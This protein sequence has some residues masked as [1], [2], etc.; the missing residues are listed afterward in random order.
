MKRASILAVYILAVASLGFAQSFIPG[1]LPKDP[2]SMGMGGS[3]RVFATGYDAFFGNPAGFSGP[4]SL[5]LADIAAWA[6]FEPYPKNIADIVAIAEGEFTQEEYAQ[7]LGTR[8]A[9]NDF[10]AGASLGLGWSGLGFG[11]GLTLVSDSV[12]RGQTWEDSKIVFCNQLDG[13]IGAA[14]PLRLGAF[15]FTFGFN[16]RAFYRLDSK[17]PWNFPALADGFL[18][19]NDFM[20]LF[21]AQNLRGGYGVAVDS[22]AI[23]TLGP[24][25]AGVMIRD[26]GY[27]FY[28]GDAT[29]GEIIEETLPPLGGTFVY[30]L[31]PTYTVGLKAVLVDTYKTFAVVYAEVDDPVSFAAMLKVDPEAA[32]LSAHY[33]AE[34]EMSRFLSLRTGYNQ[35]RL[36]LGLGFDFSL[37]EVDAA[38]FSEPSPLLPSGSRTGVSIQTAL[39]F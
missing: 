23:L 21:K 34:L 28:M 22:G 39:R 2:H 35:G 16:V 6:Y 24:L 3:F 31:I 7:F 38:I 37:I 36:S 19:N 13:I 4:A 27:K 10:G 32:F 9:D 18:Q 15:S 33:G 30:A 17:T 1:L 8:I 11:M 5:T 29:V 12:V 20:G 26:Y 25:S 14:W